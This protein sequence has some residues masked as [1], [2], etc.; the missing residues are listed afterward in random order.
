[1]FLLYNKS[2]SLTRVYVKS[3]YYF[4]AY[5]IRKATWRFSFVITKGKAQQT[6]Y[7]MLLVWRNI[8]WILFYML[9]YIIKTLLRIKLHIKHT[10]WKCCEWNYNKQKKRNNLKMLEICWIRMVEINGIVRFF[11]FFFTYD[12]CD[13]MK[14]HSLILYAKLRLLSIHNYGFAKLRS[15]CRL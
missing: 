2:V 15:Q 13:R 10:R 9:V 5:R 3:I 1:M 12:D 14:R 7:W 8:D 6:S 4:A 11:F